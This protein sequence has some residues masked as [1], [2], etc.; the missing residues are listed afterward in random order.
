MIGRMFCASHP[1]AAAA[2]SASPSPPAPALF[3]AIEPFD[4]GTLA[5]GDGHRLYYE[6]LGAPEGMPLLFLHGGPG[7]GCSARHRQLLDPARFRSVLFDQ[8]GCGRSTPRGSI[9]A[10]TTAHLLADIEALRRQL[11]IERWLVFGGSWGS[12]L[13]LAYCAQHR[14][15][16]LGAILRGLFLGGRADIE[17]FFHGAGAVLAADWLDLLAPLPAPSPASPQ[18]EQIA[19]FYVDALRSEDGDLAAAAVHPWMQWEAALTSPT[20]SLTATAPP[21][22]AALAAALDKYRIQAHYLAHE[23]FLGANAVLDC[24]ARLAGLPVALL[25]GRL[26]LVCRSRAALQVHAALPGSRLRFIDD[27][28]HSPFDAGMSAAL[29]EACAHFHAHGEFTAWG[30]SYDLPHPAFTHFSGALP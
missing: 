30:R 26:D 5:V 21:S 11:G 18:P 2:V 20:R 4:A 17:W 7:S 29:I 1:P 10:N 13:A 28:G 6:Q 25:H 12:T 3:A 24:A 8:R 19:A 27:A 14:D 22:G 16:C 9:V 23:C 15:A